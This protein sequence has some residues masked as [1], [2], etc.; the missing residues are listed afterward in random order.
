M[1]SRSRFALHFAVVCGGAL[2]V[3]PTIY[4]A[5]TKAKSKVAPAVAA[6]TLKFDGWNYEMADEPLESRWSWRATIKSQGDGA[7]RV[8]FGWKD[9]RNFAAFGS[10]V[11]HD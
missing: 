5:P 6:P 9:A 2:L 4:A 10:R 11:H 1:F 3:A 7:G 8:V